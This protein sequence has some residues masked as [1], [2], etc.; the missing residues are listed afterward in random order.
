MAFLLP[1]LS[2]GLLCAM[3]RAQTSG[4]VPARMSSPGSTPPSEDRERV[5]AQLLERVAGGDR[6]AFAQIYARFSGPLYGTALRI[7][8]DAA[9]A[10]DV[11]HD[12][13]LAIWN[14]ASTY[15]TS[16]GTAF[17]WALTMVRN[18]AIDRLRMRRRRQELLADA[19]TADTEHLS[20]DAGPSGGEAAASQDEA[21]VVRAA[22]ASLPRE[23][24]R[25]LEL[26][27]FSG[28]TQE[29][30][31]TKLREPLGTVKARIRR[32]LI[33]LRSTLVRP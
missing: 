15:E 11:V 30:I 19:A 12:G 32:G 6:E 5:D 18:R 28:L 31:A 7:L 24:Q 29:Q 26:A 2:A 22:V 9:E 25:A 13:F 4:R 20:T 8:Q 16:R 21:Q 10:Q 1:C 17:S 33:K 23:Q 27:F 3:D 14:K